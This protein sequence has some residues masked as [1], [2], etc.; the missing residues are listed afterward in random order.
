MADTNFML[1]PGHIVMTTWGMV[2]M[3]TCGVWGDSRVYALDKGLKNVSWLIA[4]GGLI[5]K[6]R[7]EAVVNM[8]SKPE[9]D[10]LMFVDADMVW[11]P[12]APMQLLAAAYRD[13]PDADVVGAW[14]PLRGF[15][16]LPT[17]DPGSGVWEPAEPN[18][19]PIEVMRTGSAFVLIKRRVFER[20]APPWYAVKFSRA[21]LD[22]LQEFET[23]ILTK[24]DGQNPLRDTKTWQQLEQ[25]AAADAP[26][27]DKSPYPYQHIGED[28]GFCDR[29]RGLGF[30]IVVQ[31][32][33]AVSHV[34]RMLIT[35]EKHLEALAEMRAS[36]ARASGV[37][38][39]V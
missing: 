34:D 9:N 7:N 11:K 35:P 30:R 20:M 32:N 23:Y 17:I 28:S 26:A 16:Y 3:E 31:T 37:L 25:C 10:W 12:E 13:F 21:P 24:F 5:D 14:C 38:E 36:E 6:T 22:V 27:R 29:A 1:P 19:G 18:T 33:I 2:T 39:P 4:P 15:P 8:L